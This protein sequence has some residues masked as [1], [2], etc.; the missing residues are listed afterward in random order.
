[1]SVPPKSG[2]D[3]EKPLP[4]GLLEHF[5]RPW[6]DLQHMQLVNLMVRL[7]RLRH[8]MPWASLI[9]GTAVLLLGAALGAL[10]QGGK[11]SAGTGVYVSGSVGLALAVAAIFIAQ[12]RTESIH[13]VCADFLAFAD[14]WEA[15]FP[16]YKTNADYIRR[17]AL[18]AGSELSIKERVLL[19]FGRAP[20]P[21]E[22][23][24]A[25]K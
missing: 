10:V 8:V 19:A 14:Q 4:I 9:G 7:Q 11:N 2:L 16:G 23:E 18:D 3:S 24:E 6:T 22:L 5:K 21:L 1:M 25:P 20:K 15:A 13:T 17:R 12:T